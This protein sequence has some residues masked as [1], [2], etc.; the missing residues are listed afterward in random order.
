VIKVF[1]S[2]RVDAKVPNGT[3]API[4][5]GSS[6]LADVR[7]TTGKAI[8]LREVRIEIQTQLTAGIGARLIEVLRNDNQPAQ[9]DQATL[10]LCEGWARSSDLV[11][12]IVN[13]EAGSVA[14]NGLGIC[15]AELI[16]ARNDTPSKLLL[17]QTG[18]VKV[19]FALATNS[20][21]ASDFAALWGAW[22]KFGSSAATAARIVDAS[23]DAV[24]SGIDRMNV[25]S[26]ADWR[27]RPAIAGQQL[28]WAS[29][30]Y[31]QR[32]KTLVESL[33]AELHEPWPGGKVTDVKST[34]LPAVAVTAAGMTLVLTVSAAPDSFGVPDA[35]PYV[36]YPFRNDAAT[37]EAARRSKGGA[38]SSGPL[39]IVGLFKNVT[40]SQIRNHIGN[41]DIAILPFRFGYLAHDQIQS[42]Q[43]AYLTRLSDQTAVR[44]AVTELRAAL[45]DPQVAADVR[46]L[47]NRRAI[48][49]T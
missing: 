30:P 1:V 31:S 44:R 11:L 12:A 21:F 46:R 7:G 34:G 33:L 35:R 39:H 29:R 8:D 9:T 15:H 24:V 16:A 43:V 3:G 22:K 14:P 32:A 26:L 28:D 45:G 19:N 47:A 27:Q 13:G 48:M 36:G 25:L 49:V 41:A 38:S 2:S 18:E 4:R 10:D 42:I 23:V 17:I 40:E 5:P 37:V 20:A 6:I